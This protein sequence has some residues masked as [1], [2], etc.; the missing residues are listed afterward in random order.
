MF[1]VINMST[2]PTDSTFSWYLAHKG[3]THGYTVATS[4]KNGEDIRRWIMVHFVA[5]LYCANNKTPQ[6]EAPHTPKFIER[7]P[8]DDSMLTIHVD[9]PC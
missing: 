1:A 3:L 6:V 8:T 4:S 5:F 7:S 2:R 9:H